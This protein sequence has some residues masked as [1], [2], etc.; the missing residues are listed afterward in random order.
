MCFVQSSQG[1]SRVRRYF[2]VRRESF[3]MENEMERKLA[4][5]ILDLLETLQ[6]AARQMRQ[7]HARGAG[8]QFERLSGD[9][10]D[11]LTAIRELAG[12][13]IPHG[14]GN[15]LEDACTCAL[16]SLKDIRLLALTRPEKAE[17]KLEYELGGILEAMT[18][19]FYY[20]GIVAEHPEEREN[21]LRYLAD[22]ETYRFLK[23]AE[24][25]REY[26]CDLIISVTAYN[27]LKY[28]AI[29]V[30]KI[31]D[32]MPR[33]IRCELLVMNNGSSDGTKEYFE[34]M[35][36]VKVINV[37]VNFA[38]PDAAAGF[39]RRGK[40]L[41]GVSNDVVVGS[42][43]IENLY[44]CA[45]E[46]PDYG[47]IVPSTSAVSNYQQIHLPYNSEEEFEEAAG[48]NNVYDERRHEQRVRL[49]NPVTMTRTAVWRRM[50]LEMYESLRGSR[51]FLA[52]PDDKVSLWMRRNGYK[53]ILA[54]DAYCHHF[55][56][57]TINSETTEDERAEMYQEGRKDFIIR[58]GVDPWGRNISFEPELFA[59]WD[60]RPVDGAC[61]L[62]INC[63][64]GNNPLKVKELLREQGAA[65]PHLINCVQDER[66][67]ADLKG[68]S[69]EAYVIASL[70]DIPAAAGRKYFDYI[71]AED[72]ADGYG[73][74]EWVRAVR[75][76][77][78]ECGELAYRVG[79]EWKIWR[80]QQS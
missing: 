21:F 7:E 32:N 23:E 69:D 1:I 74:E 3:E 77:G 2:A 64:L 19:Q 37:A 61:V 72:A 52:F 71:V 53:N 16:E 54:K 49:V 51:Q 18:S 78:I 70:R 55:G 50:S 33:G 75:D 31:L 40:Y 67:L 43:A 8:R 14:S 15:R 9:L 47:Y 76:A 46:H 27:K 29:C 22:T 20:W 4:Y 17:W 73:R 65:E 12:Q 41:L 13:N 62:G 45:A 36:E 30:Q 38:V 6:E 44:R 42:G 58:F 63:G 25:E 26:P 24:G 80:T 59:A 79:A 11:G 66:Y 56:S 35:E 10:Q 60:I 68:V 39:C 34:D 57:L 48:R 28:T 5:D